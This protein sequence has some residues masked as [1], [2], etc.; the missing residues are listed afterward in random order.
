MSLI[1]NVLGCILSCVV[2]SGCASTPKPTE[3]VQVQTTPI[4]PVAPIVPSVDDLRMRD[5]QWVVV[6]EENYQGVLMRLRGTGQQPVLYALTPAG[7]SNLI[8]NQGDVMK[9]IRQQKEVILIYRRSY[10]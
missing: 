3:V 4:K 9:V 1:R 8:M 2:I 6:T 7:Y 5:V 10:Q